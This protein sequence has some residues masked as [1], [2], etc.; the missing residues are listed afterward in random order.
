MNVGPVLKPRTLRCAQNTVASLERNVVLTGH[1]P[2]AN[3]HPARKSAETNVANIKK[4]VVRTSIVVQKDI[5]VV[6]MGHAKRIAARKSAEINVAKMEKPVVIIRVVAHPDT[7]VVRMG[8]AKSIAVPTN[9]RTVLEIAVKNGN[10]ERHIGL[11]EIAAHGVRIIYIAVTTPT[12]YLAMS[13]LFI[14]ATAEKFA[15]EALYYGY[16]I[17]G[18]LSL[19][20]VVTWLMQLPSF[21][22]CRLVNATVVFSSLS[23]DRRL[24]IVVTL[25]T[26]QLCRPFIVVAWL[27]YRK[28]SI[29]RQYS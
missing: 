26:Q 18:Q 19:F 3:R 11:C 12:V 1:A 8:H 5:N 10:F 9:A 2:R 25:L 16:N 15:P 27:M 22:R 21:H 6:R 24:F 13:A 17:L 23:L 20:I 29:I 14:L 4:P 28:S 7:I